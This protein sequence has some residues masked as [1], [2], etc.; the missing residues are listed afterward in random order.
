MNEFN[1]APS[2]SSPLDA[3]LLGSSWKAINLGLLWTTG[4]ILSLA[5]TFQ[6]WFPFLQKRNIVNSLIFC[7]TGKGTRPGQK[8]EMFEV[9]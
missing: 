6:T 3:P 8:E 5:V 2:S 4:S 9:Y 7:L 1:P